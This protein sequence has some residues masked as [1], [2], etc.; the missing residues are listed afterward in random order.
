MVKFKLNHLTQRA[1]T[2]I[3]QVD[4]FIGERNKPVSYNNRGAR[5]SPAHLAIYTT[6]LKNSKDVTLNGASMN[7]Y[8][9][10]QDTLVTEEG[11][12]V[13]Y[14]YTFMP[15]ESN[16]YQNSVIRIKSDRSKIS[17]F[18]EK[19]VIL[20]SI[21]TSFFIVLLVIVLLFVSNTITKPLAR[22]TKS[23]NS[24]S[25]GS[26]NER[27]DAGGSKEI[28]QL[29]HRFNQMIENIRNDFHDL[30]KTVK[31]DKV[32][33]T[34]HLDE[35]QIQKDQIQ[36]QREDLL[37]LNKNVKE[38]FRKLEEQNKL[39]SDSVHYAHR[40][41]NIL[42]PTST[43]L[44][45]ALRDY[46]I[47]YKPRNVVGGD[48]YWAVKVGSKSVV[49]CADCTGHG[50]PGAFMSI[51]GITMLNKIVKENHVV[52]PCEILEQLR[53][54]IIGALLSTEGHIVRDGVDVS[55]A[56]IDHEQN[57][58]DYVGANS[59]IVLVQDEEIRFVKGSKQSLGS[60]SD[61]LKPFKKERIEYFPGDVLYLFTDG[62]QD[63]FGGDQDKKFMIKRL[64]NLF[65]R[66]H[67]LPVAEQKDIINS[68]IEDWMI[69]SRQVDD[70]LIIG[71]KL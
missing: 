23:L 1:N 9:N 21:V 19:K 63:Q 6:V 52:D 24:V 8:V 32:R 67:E 38:S 35:I 42:L 4:L 2:S 30:E 10:T 43:N 31:K 70:M 5:I 36:T 71:V 62:Y 15:R 41:E 64:R 48:F 65:L 54:S 27:S 50:V 56:V 39:I 18:R 61:D 59:P 25:E 28:R 14:Q 13:H 58:I 57:Y 53:V 60:S 37:K 20:Y 29:S 40:V 17:E 66:V 11:L 12:R 47:L 49:A 44:E 7:G 55:V 3:Q 69:N 45:E 46:F 34:D 26:L 16:I 68:T 33:E 22:L 51:I